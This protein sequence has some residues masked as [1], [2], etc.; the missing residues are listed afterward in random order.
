M[1]INRPCPMAAEMADRIREMREELTARWLERI[2]ARVQLEPERIFPSTQLLDHVPVLMDGIAG[3]LEDPRDEI[4]AD[5]PVIAKAME[6]G[7]L[8]FAQGFDASEILKEYE[9]LGGVLFSFAA[10]VVAESATESTPEDLL[11][12]SHRLFRA[13]SVI[14]QVTTAHYLRVLGERVGEREERLRRFNRMLTHE[15]KN[16]VGATLGAGQLLQEEW[17][18]DEER[19]RFAGMVTDNAQAIQK[20][21]ENLIALSRMEGERRRQR[22]IMLREV[23]TEVFRQLREL[24]RARSVELRVAGDLPDIEVNAAAVELCL[25]NYVSNAIKYANMSASQRWAE[26]TATIEPADSGEES[27]GELVVRVRDN[28]LGV[29]DEKRV[30][31]FERFF[32]AHENITTVE[33]TG[34]G[35]SL[36]QETTE[37]LGG[38]VWV[39]FNED[40]GSVFA[41]ALPCRRDAD[42]LSAGSVRSVAP[43]TRRPDAV[44]A[45]VS[46]S[47]L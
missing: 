8:R 35:L 39:E 21:L 31:L 2:S 27:D 5:L 42:R 37:S 38:R 9:L 11:I 3:Y 34:L 46:D 23:V 19:K 15:L 24:A 17:L 1:D 25:S 41:F 32:R 44:Q 30:H 45:I 12:C 7:E 20:V 36:V 14:E 22:N 10:R 28:G 43:R 6:L 33:G 13:I 16:R 26:V 47:P 4:T 29:P 18:S 40:G